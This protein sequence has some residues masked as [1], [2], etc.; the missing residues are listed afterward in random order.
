MTY[1]QK[2]YLIIFGSLFFIVI[3]LLSINESYYREYKNEI[4]IYGNNASK[5][6]VRETDSEDYT[7]HIKRQLEKRGLKNVVIEMSG[8]NLYGMENS[9]YIEATPPPT[10]LDI[11][12]N[13]ELKPIWIKHTYINTRFH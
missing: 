11:L 12:I 10:K 5:F 7:S 4:M 1:K 3:F 8:E 6:I 9:I 13:R 2:K